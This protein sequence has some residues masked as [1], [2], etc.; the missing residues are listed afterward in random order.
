MRS[1]YASWSL[2]CCFLLVSSA[3]VRAQQAPNAG[4]VLHGIEQNTPPPSGPAPQPLT[5]L[6]ETEEAPA[7]KEGE[8]IHVTGFHIIAT[9]YSETTL[10]AV[11]KKWANQD[12]TLG[13]LRDAAAEIS[14]YYRDHGFLARA[15][16]PK[17]TIDGGL[18][19]IQ[20]IEPKLGKV[21]VD[22]ASHNRFDANSAIDIVNAHQAAG[23][24]LRFDDVE[25]GISALNDQPGL[26]A[27]GTLEAGA[28]FG[29]TDVRL[30][31]D[32]GPWVTGALIVDNDAARTLGIWRGVG[33][34]SL[35]DATGAGDQQSVTLV[36]SGY[37]GRSA[38][39]YVNYEAT[40][41][42]GTS[43]LRL[44]VIGAGSRYLVSPDFNITEPSGW[45]I[46]GGVEAMLPI[47]RDDSSAWDAHA[48]YNH[49]YL[50][51]QIFGTLPTAITSIDVG[52]IGVNGTERDLVPSGVLQASVTLTGGRLN[53]TG[54]QQN[55]FQDISTTGTQGLY[56]KA[57]ASVALYERLDDD[58]QLI[59]RL[60]GQVASKNLDSSEQFSLGG[61]DAIRAYPVNEGLGS[62]G[63]LG[64]IGLQYQVDEHLQLEPFWDGGVL[65][66]YVTTWKT[67]VYPPFPPVLVSTSPNIYGLEG[68]GA[69][70]R[71]TPTSWLTFDFTGSH[72]LGT[73]PGNQGGYDSDS[74]REKWR[75]WVRMTASF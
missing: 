48:T 15:I 32:E 42:V 66:Q 46:D 5:P 25:A 61:P 38:S 44:G 75:G 43:G 11:V 31:L 62:D 51:S 68:I 63:L 27:E 17:Q 59:F 33:E 3:S 26:K 18:V 74:E 37:G 1:R 50:V 8:T 35:N 19:T 13:D 10:Q 71:W 30:K 6:P 40:I 24:P 67:Y 52:T 49:K 23:N 2:G 14:K 41:G 73:N 69:T 29:T 12:C 47:W 9:L 57:N 56:F 34:L 16:L 65:R 53:L 55:E 72:T 60:N 28:E 45:T 20:V 4:S 39:T 70:V 54:D 21:V 22:P 7:I 58:L 64:T 36:R